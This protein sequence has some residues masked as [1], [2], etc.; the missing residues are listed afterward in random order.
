MKKE[1]LKQMIASAIND[2]EAHFELRLLHR[3]EVKRIKECV[4]Y[5]IYDNVGT[6]KKMY[7]TLI[8]DIGLRYI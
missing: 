7:R 1:K 4:S 3:I 8:E 2:I 5:P 6:L